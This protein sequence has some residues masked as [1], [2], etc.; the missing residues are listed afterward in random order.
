MSIAPTM[1]TK[2]E[3]KMITVAM[4]IYMYN[5]LRGLVE[6]TNVCYYTERGRLHAE[7]DVH[8]ETF[9]RVSAERGWN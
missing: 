8:E 3:D 1:I 6:M 9:D 5:D 7:A 2:G 4:P